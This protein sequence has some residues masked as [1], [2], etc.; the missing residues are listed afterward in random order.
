MRAAALAL[1]LSVAAIG[2]VSALVARAVQETRPPAGASLGERVYYRFCVDCHGRDGRG[3]WRATLMLI[4]PGDLSNQA[5]MRDHADQ[6]LFDLVKHGGSPV[7]KPGMPGFGFNLDDAQIRAVVAY[8][9][10]LG[11]SP[12]PAAP[13]GPPAAGA[14]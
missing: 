14:R 4:R 2:L 9:R 8:V 13:P 11:R 6:Y 12:A 1:A 3:S 5:R 7:G 10:T